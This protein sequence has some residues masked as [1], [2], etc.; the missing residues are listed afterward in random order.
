MR[1]GAVTGTGLGSG[2]P[3]WEH[4]IDGSVCGLSVADG[5]V[6]VL[7]EP[8]RLVLLD[9]QTGQARGA[10]TA[11]GTCLRRDPPGHPSPSRAGTWSWRCGTRSWR[12]ARG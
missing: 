3:R 9:T 1:G 5:V 2:R 8:G 11:P 4:G 6:Y 12:W 10:F 7:A